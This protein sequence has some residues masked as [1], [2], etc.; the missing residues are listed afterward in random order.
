MHFEFWD[1]VLVWDA[2]ILDFWKVLTF[3]FN[4]R[5]IVFD[6]IGSVYVICRFLGKKRWHKLDSPLSLFRFTCC[7]LL[8]C[9]T[10]NN[11]ISGDHSGAFNYRFDST[12][13]T[14]VSGCDGGYKLLSM[15]IEYWVLTVVRYVQMGW[16]LCEFS[17]QSIHRD[18]NLPF[19]LGWHVFKS[20]MLTKQF[21]SIWMHAHFASATFYKNAMWNVCMC[22]YQQKGYTLCRV[23]TNIDFCSIC[24]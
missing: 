22:E 2:P 5:D 6:R 9:G 4:I 1:I 20:S 17:F 12:E 16:C 3:L 14:L 24:A 10:Q 18:K 15:P 8:C 11:I 13:S 19:A 21:Q 23:Q 7:K